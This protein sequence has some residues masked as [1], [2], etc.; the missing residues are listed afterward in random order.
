MRVAGLVAQSLRGAIKPD[1]PRAAAIASWMIAVCDG[2][3]LQWLLDPG[4]MPSAAELNA[5]LALMWRAS[6]EV[7]RR[8][9]TL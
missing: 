4:S 8:S 7:G 6:T 9:S 3:A 5:G 2:L 1:D